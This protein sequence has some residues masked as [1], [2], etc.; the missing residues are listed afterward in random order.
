MSLISHPCA[1]PNT[2]KQAQ[3]GAKGSGGTL[4]SLGISGSTDLEGQ[5]D[6]GTLTLAKMKDKVRSVF[7]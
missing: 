1:D 5:P 7:V 2:K 6:A 4:K 3:W